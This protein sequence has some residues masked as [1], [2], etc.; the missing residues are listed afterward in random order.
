M[1]NELD[2]ADF[3]LAIASPG[4]RASADGRAPASEGRGAHFESAMLRDK[5]TQNRDVWIGK[6][7]PVVLPGNTV[8]DDIPDFL[9]PYAATHYV[10]ER[11]TPAGTHPGAALPDLSAATSRPPLSPEPL[12]TPTAEPTRRGATDQ[13]QSQQDQADHHG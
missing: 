1:I 2:K 6:I 3:V 11:L 8:D 13:R 7:L 9:L 5:M 4:F 10:I 12:V